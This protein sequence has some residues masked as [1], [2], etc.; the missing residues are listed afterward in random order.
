MVSFQDDKTRLAPLVLAHGLMGFNRVGLSSW[1]LAVYFRGIPQFLEQF[2]F[3]I[4]TPRV[5]PMAGIRQRAESLARQIDRKFPGEPIHL[6][7]HSMGGL[8][9]RQLASLPGWSERILSLTTV[10]SPHLGSLLGEHFYPY[11]RPLRSLLDAVGVDHRGFRDVLPEF[12][13][14]WHQETIAPPGVPCF[15]MAG[16]PPG[17]S[18]CWPLRQLA[19]IHQSLDGPNDGLVSVRS[20]LAFG[21]PLMTLP[22]DHFHQMNWYTSSRGTQLS[23]WVQTLYGTIGRTLLQHDPAFRFLPAQDQEPAKISEVKTQPELGIG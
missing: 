6:I 15:S 4:Y 14:R 9:V 23:P 1:T 10:G 16:N 19:R 20:A 2:G 22:I 17:S 3:R 5:H 21:Q 18:V 7:G 8:D 11:S 13:L 12:A